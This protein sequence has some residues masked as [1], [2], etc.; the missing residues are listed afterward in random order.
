MDFE[1]E[2][3]LFRAPERSLLEVNE[4]RSKEKASFAGQ[5]TR[6]VDAP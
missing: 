2:R 1:P 3:V 4:H 6:I 5:K